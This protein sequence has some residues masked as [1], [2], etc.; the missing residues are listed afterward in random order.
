MK[1]QTK[2][3]TPSHHKT[4]YN[5]CYKIKTFMRLCITKTII[6]HKTIVKMD[7]PPFT[8]AIVIES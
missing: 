7:E 3:Y 1:N 5:N 4:K 8:S 6:F 2:K